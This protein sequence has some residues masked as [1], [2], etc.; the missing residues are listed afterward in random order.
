[1]IHWLEPSGAA[2]RP[3]SVM[4]SLST[5]HGR[6]VRRCLR[7]GASCSVTASAQTPV[8][9]AIPA[10]SQRGDPLPAHVRVGVDDADDDAGDPGAR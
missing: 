6:P 7:Y 3:S 5:T 2:V 1:M 4:A 10:A 8:V 9:T